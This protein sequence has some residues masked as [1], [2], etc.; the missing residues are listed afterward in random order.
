LQTSKAS[1]LTE[2]AAGRISPEVVDASHF[3]RAENRNALTDPRTRLLLAD[4]RSHLRLGRLRYD[5]VISEPS[6]PWRAGIA[7]LFTREFLIEVRERLTEAG[8]FCQWA[9][10]YDISDPDLRSIVATFVDVFPHASLW[11]IGEA[12]VLLM[13]A[14]RARARSGGDGDSSRAGS[15]GR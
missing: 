9:H 10:T 1:R 4:G 2:R 11:L 7:A 15:G 6:N 8:I 13:I 3:F 14:R 12:D 5:V